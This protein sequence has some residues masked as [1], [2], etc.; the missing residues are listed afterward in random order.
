MCNTVLQN[1]TTHWACEFKLPMKSDI[2]DKR[3]I[4]NKSKTG[5][6]LRYSKIY[7]SQHNRARILLKRIF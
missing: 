1:I 5:R 3:K 6:K 2:L 7:K 4:L